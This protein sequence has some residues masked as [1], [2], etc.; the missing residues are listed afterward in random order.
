MNI[1]N[2]SLSVA[3]SL[4]RSQSAKTGA[5]AAARPQFTVAISREVGALGSTIAREIGRR[6]ECPVYD[7][8]IVEKVAEDLKKPASEIRDLDERP[9]FWIEDWIIGLAR[10]DIVSAD[11]YL[12]HLVAAMRGVAELGRC[13]I[14]GRGA[15]RILPPERTVRVRL[16][17]DRT[18]RIANI[19]K[20]R[21]CSERDAAEWVDRV[22]KE[23]TEF[24][25]RSFGADPADPHQYDLVLN[26]SRLS[27]HECAE[28][29]I[30][31]FL[32]ME[33]RAGQQVAL[34]KP[35]GS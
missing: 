7:R 18:D 1:P 30:Q 25:L 23:R 4:L 5:R 3:D 8:E 17:A 6:L 9:T 32:R 29:V 31:A 34:V 28:V 24:A 12:R 35:G 27:V 20:Q 10:K 19:S 33:A 2:L 22:E 13:V 16:I 14:V 11:T 26:T 15:P 21:Q